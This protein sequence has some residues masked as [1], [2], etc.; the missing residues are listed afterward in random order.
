VLAFAARRLL[1]TIPVLI[2]VSIV[3]FLFLRLIPGDPAVVL[4]G[5]RATEQSVQRVREQLG[6]DQPLHV[7]YGRYLARLARFDL[8]RS[9]RSNRPVWDEARSRFPATVELSA[10]ALAVAVA[11]GVGGG[12]VSATWRGS[13]VDHVS[14]VLAL[15]GISMPIFWLGLVLIW[16]FAVQLRWLPPDGRLDADTRYAPITNFVLVDAL[17][18]RRGDLALTAVRHLVLPALALSTVPMAIIARMTRGAMLEVLRAD[19]VR[20][21][22]AK[23]MGWRV[24]DRRHVLRNAMLPVSTVIGL[25]TGLLLSGAIL[26]ETVFSWGGMG[27]WMYQAIGNRDFP[28]IQGGILFLAVVFVVVN[29]LV[30]LSYA[31]LDPRIR[32]RA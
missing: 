20:T 29:L 17:L 10:A 16:V 21:A 14:R 5:E 8:G 25:Q 30:D 27:Q 3:V 2:G 13:A 31:V 6:L 18:Q 1:E 28:V 22:R 24:V 23:G 32:V 26:T 7:Q 12:I 15:T 11:V 19:Y 4:L 9:I